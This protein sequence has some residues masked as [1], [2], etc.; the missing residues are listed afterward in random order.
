MDK[1][2]EAMNSTRTWKVIQFP[3]LKKELPNKWVYKVKFRS[4]GTL[5]RLKVRLVIRGD[6]QRE[7]IDYTETFL[8]S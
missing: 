7:G 3:L 1:E 5:E 2:L 8:R 4:N 6:I